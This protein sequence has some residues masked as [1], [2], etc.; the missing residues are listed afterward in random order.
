MGGGGPGGGGVSGAGWGWGVLQHHT[1][2]A[3]QI[4]PSRLA[5]CHPQRCPGLPTGRVREAAGGD[6]AHRA[7]CA[8]EV[9]RRMQRPAQIPGQFDRPGREVSHERQSCHERRDQ[10]VQPVS[11]PLGPRGPARRCCDCLLR[12]QPVH[13]VGGGRGPDHEEVAANP[14]AFRA[15]DVAQLARRPDPVGPENARYLLEVIDEADVLVPCWGARGKVPRSL[16]SHLDALAALLLASGKPV[17]V[18][19]LTA[20]GDPLQ[21][22]DAGLRD[23]AGR[24]E[25]AVNESRTLSC[26]WPNSAPVRF[27]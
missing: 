14:F 4:M 18:L 8:A 6:P 19:G 10:S 5:M 16:H 15:T 13:R 27:R 1:S 22:V 25:A 21:T 2:S 23:A 12:R 17:R 26:C 20:S 7:G 24:L 3:R 11:V 9:A